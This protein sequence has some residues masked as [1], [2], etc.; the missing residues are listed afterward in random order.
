MV[1]LSLVI[2]VPWYKNSS[3]LQYLFMDQD[4]SVPVGYCYIRYLLGCR[5]SSFVFMEH[6]TL[7]HGIALQN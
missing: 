3:E 2:L 5:I 4:Y 6:V 1:A 7:I